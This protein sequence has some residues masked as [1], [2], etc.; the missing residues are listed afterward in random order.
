MILC[1]K[2]NIKPVIIGS[3]W[4][5]ALQLDDNLRAHS[6]PTSVISG[7]YY[8]YIESKQSPLVFENIASP[9]IKEHNIRR[10]LRNVDDTSGLSKKD[11]EVNDIEFYP[12]NESLILF[13]SYLTHY[14]NSLKT[15]KRYTVVFNTSL[16]SERKAMKPHIRDYRVE[17]HEDK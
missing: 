16:Y 5:N 1:E 2:A 13:P 12:Q 4:I 17:S 11:Y 10:I 6:H 3:N 9:I 15:H 8:P 14:V 7:V